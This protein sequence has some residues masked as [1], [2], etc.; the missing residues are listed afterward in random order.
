MLF[1]FLAGM[2]LAAWIYRTDIRTW[3]TYAAQ[4]R[5]DL[6]AANQRAG[7]NAIHAHGRQQ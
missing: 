6:H 2:G 5:R 3:Q 7:I 1:A 4:A